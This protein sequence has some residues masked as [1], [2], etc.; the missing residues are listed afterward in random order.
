MKLKGITH[1]GI[2]RLA[3]RMTR[4]AQMGEQSV[5]MSMS[6]DGMEE[7]TIIY[8]SGAVDMENEA[9][10]A[11]IEW[12]SGLGLKPPATIEWTATV[13]GDEIFTGEVEI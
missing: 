11:C 7:D 2:K 6:V 10:K 12:A 4:K 3:G 13:Y 5:T 8:A 1:K 9:E